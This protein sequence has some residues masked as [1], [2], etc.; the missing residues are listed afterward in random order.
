[1]TNLYTDKIT[2]GFP[3]PI[4]DPILGLPTYAT[5]KELHVQLNSNAASIFMNIGD[6]QHDLLRLAVSNAQYNS[7]STV[8]FV[9]PANPGATVTYLPNATSARIKHADDTHDKAFILFK[10]YTL[11]DK[12]LKQLLLVAIE[13]KHYRVLRNDLIGC[14]NVTTRDLIQHLYTCYGNSTSTQLTNNA[15]TLRSG[16]DPNQPIK[17]LY[18]QIDNAVAFVASADN[19]YTDKQTVSIGY[20][21]M[22]QTGVYADDCKV[23]WKKPDADKTWPAFKVFFTDANQ[24]LRQSK[25]TPGSAGY[26]PAAT[27]NLQHT[28]NTL[29]TAIESV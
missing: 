20:E 10:E 27:I 6:G 17:S 18:E 1:M 29:T 23:W 5:I 4:V 13:E 14:A 22:F 21:I 19:E 15:I 9:A 26:H 16:Y 28:L 25:A 24:D 11:A 7:V 2:A 8:P 3:R 12:V